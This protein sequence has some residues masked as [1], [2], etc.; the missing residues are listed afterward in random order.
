ML[1]KNITI[2]NNK[3]QVKYKSIY[4]GVYKTLEEALYIL[5][6]TKEDFE[7]KRIENINNSPIKRNEKGECIIELFNKKKEK[8]AETIVDENIYYDLIKYKW[9]PNGNYVS[10]LIN[11]KII[12][13]HR[14]IMNYIGENYVDHINNNSLDNKKCNLRIVTPQQNSM[15]CSSSKNSSSKYIGVSKN[16]NTYKSEIKINGIRIQLGTFKL[17]I[18]AAKA[19]DIA[20]KEHFGEFGKLNFLEIN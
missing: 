15:N 13:L 2:K 18:D 20:T 4:Y 19:R 1:P 16:H 3:F 12:L 10:A 14:Y 11:R 6:K 8:V 17:E 5:K 9:Y 7:L